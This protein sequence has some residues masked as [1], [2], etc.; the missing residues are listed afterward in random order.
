VFEIHAGEPLGE[1]QTVDA[2]QLA[3]FAVQENP[4]LKLVRSRV[5]VRQSL[6][7]EAGLFPNPEFGWDGMDALA[8]E[9]SGDG[10]GS[11]EFL[12]GLGISFPLLRPGERSALKGVAQAELDQAKAEVLAAEWRLAGFVYVACEDLLEAKAQWLLNQELAA[13]LEATRDYFERA[14]QAGTATA[15]QAN[16]AQGDLL[17]IHAEGLQRQA[18]LRRAKQNL[19]ALLGLPPTVDLPLVALQKETP[20]TEQT[21]A[22]YVALALAQR[23]DLVVLQAAYQAAEENLRLEVRRQFPQMS[24]GTGFSFIPGLFNHWNRPAI[25]TAEA[26]RQQLQTALTA[27]IHQL[28]KDVFARYAALQESELEFHYLQN[29]V[30]PNA[31]RSR[32]LAEGAFDAGEVTLLEILAV[33]RSWVATRTRMK[34][35]Q[36]ELARR[37]WQLLTAVGTLLANEPSDSNS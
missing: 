26:Q 28:R 4:G 23:P 34:E 31:V 37:H 6:L 5:G 15:I 7:E 19:N 25:R 13:V 14:M 18:T 32:E 30:L 17:E 12:S 24:I 11:V 2:R 29:E 9:I 16:L 35:A 33:Q 3:V 20:L 22:D 1:E 10:A 21:A 8:A 27:E 36:A